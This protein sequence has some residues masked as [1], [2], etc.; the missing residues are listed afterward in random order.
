MS[1]RQRAERMLMERGLSAE[2]EEHCRGT[3][4]QAELLARRWGAAPDDAAIA[5]LLHDLC[6][7]LSPEEILRLA[8]EHG[9]ET[10]TIEEQY[11]VQLLHARVA[12][13][14]VARA[15]FA[16]PV[17]EAVRRHTLGGSGMSVLDACLFVA[18]ATEPGRTWKGVDAVRR[19]AT[20]SLDAAV[21]SLARR[22]VERLR[23]R[24]RAPHP[25]MLALLEEKHG[26][27]V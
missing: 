7:E 25:R 22:D 9:L 2:L 10:D 20:E 14:E 3:A 1:E 13:E 23:A 26:A 15:G 21:L 24:G 4:L 27:Q 16:P 6:R 18:D 19:Q 17:A 12:A 11:A 8:H 5:G